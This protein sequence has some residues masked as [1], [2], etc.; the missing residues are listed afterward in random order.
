[1]NFESNAAKTIAALVVLNI[2]LFVSHHAPVKG[3]RSPVV[4][5]S[6][7]QQ[8]AEICKAR[9]E[10]RKAAMEARLHARAAAREMVRARRQASQAAVMAPSASATKCRTSVTDYVRTLVSSGMRT[11]ASGI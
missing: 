8:R 6:V 4:Q 7:M 5:A 1:M 10:A 3:L 11:L 2:G 9:I